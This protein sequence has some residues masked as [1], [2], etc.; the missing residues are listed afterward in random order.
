MKKRALACIG[1]MLALTQASAQEAPAAAGASA[2]AVHESR[3]YEIHCDGGREAAEVLGRELDRKFETYQRLFRFG[4]TLAAHRFRVVSIGESTAYD[5]YVQARLGEPRPGA[6]YLH[7]ASPEKRELVVHRNSG[8]LEGILAQQGFIQYLRGFVSAPPTWMRE[9]FAVYFNTLGYDPDVDELSYEENLT[10]LETVKA[11]GNGGPTLE[12]VLGF[13]IISAQALAQGTAGEASPGPADMQAASWAFVS[14]LLNTEDQEYRRTLFESFLVLQDSASAAENSWAVLL[15][16][17]PWVDQEALRQ[18]FAMYLASRKTFADLLG[19]GQRAYAKK[20]TA[21]AELSFLGAL[22]LKPTHPAP[23]YYLGLLAYEQKAFEMAENHY[24][25]A[26]QYGAD[27]ALTQYALGLNAAAAGRS[28]AARDY[29]NA[30]KKADP[31]RYGAK[32]DEALAR[33]K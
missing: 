3:W 6:V 14:F 23:Y 4:P 26:L 18:D 27:P 28:A 19:E 13:D 17:E 24:R 16:A 11:W 10:W 20:D 32:A 8:D 7:Y 30:A 15:R 1:L 21:Q 33:L 12:S 9:G 2:P 5:A 25:S 31:A 22:D 29:L